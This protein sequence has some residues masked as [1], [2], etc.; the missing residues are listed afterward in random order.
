MTNEASQKLALLSQK[1]EGHV[2][3]GETDED[4]IKRVT[5]AA[6]D[7]GLNA[8]VGLIAFAGRDV[9]G[10]YFVQ[11][12]LESGN[13]YSSQ[14]PAWAYEIAQ[15]ALVNKKKVWVI[16]DGDPFGFNLQQVHILGQDV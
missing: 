14:W 9:D 13:G 2:S 10:V 11:V 15:S 8:E 4:H 1:I 6:A 16:S 12:N 3:Q 5:K 7:V